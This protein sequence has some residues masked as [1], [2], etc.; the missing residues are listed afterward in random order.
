MFR[1]S[2]PEGLRFVCQLYARCALLKP[3]LRGSRKSQSSPQRKP[4]GWQPNARSRSVTPCL[5]GSRKGAPVTAG[6]QRL[7]SNGWLCKG[8]GHNR[9]RCVAIQITQL[10]CPLL[11]CQKKVLGNSPVRATARQFTCRQGRTSFKFHKVD[12]TMELHNAFT[13]PLLSATMGSDPQSLPRE[14]RQCPSHAQM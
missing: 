7:K 4:S 5:R 9:L 3:C 11:F 12:R 1:T 10:A 8:E 14:S 13:C 2:W 6:Y